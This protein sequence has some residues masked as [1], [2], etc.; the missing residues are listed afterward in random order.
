MFPDSISLAVSGTPWKICISDVRRSKDLIE[1]FD[2]PL[3]T[4]QAAKESK[5]DEA[6]DKVTESFEYVLCRVLKSVH[7]S[8]PASQSCEH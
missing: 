8:D 3:E 6:V 7:E 5:K 1:L 4:F 2:V